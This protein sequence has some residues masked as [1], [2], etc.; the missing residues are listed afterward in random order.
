MAEHMHDHKNK[1]GILLISGIIV[2]I[3]ALQTAVSF[4]C[5]DSHAFVPLA[6][7]ICPPSLWPFLDYPMYSDS[8]HEGDSIMQYHLVGVL[9]DFTKVQIGPDDLDMG[10]WRFR[11]NVVFELLRNQ[12]ERVNSVVE[13]YQLKYKKR[14]REIYLENHPLIL[15]RDGLVPGKPEVLRSFQVKPD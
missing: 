2:G 6:K 8:H 1:L 4:C 7:P 10:F 9:E 11:K 13:L 14:L 12:D 3:L 15:R 5:H